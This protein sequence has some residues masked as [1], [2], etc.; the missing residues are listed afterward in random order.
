MNERK[1]IPEEVFIDLSQEAEQRATGLIL[2]CKF[3]GE[4]KPIADKVL[5][6]MVTTFCRLVDGVFLD[7]QAARQAYYRYYESQELGHTLPIS[8]ALVSV[9]HHIENCLTNMKRMREMAEAVRTRKLVDGS[10]ALIESS[11][12]R[13]A[14]THEG[15]IAKIRNGL[16][17]CH[18]DLKKGIN[19]SGAAVLR[20]T[21]HIVFGCHELS[22]IDLVHTLK[23]YRIISLKVATALYA[24]KRDL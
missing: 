14:Q 10:G 7:Y 6:T 18:N 22:L 5:D 19:A 11:D 12:W 20:E 3:S 15:I 4:G 24:G 16:Q 1:V 2:R 21:G 13:I 8:E 17:H 9:F 23:T